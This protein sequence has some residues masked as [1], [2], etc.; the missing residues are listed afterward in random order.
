MWVQRCMMP[1]HWVSIHAVAGVELVDVDVHARAGRPF[2]HELGEH[3][4]EVVY[5]QAH[6]LVLSPLG[7]LVARLRCAAC[8]WDRTWP[9]TR[10]WQAS[11]CSNFQGVAARVMRLPLT[12]STSPPIC[13][14]VGM[15][16]P[17]RIRW[18]TF[19]SGCSTFRIQAGGLGVLIDE[20][21][22]LR[23]AAVRAHGRGERMIDVRSVDAD[24]LGL[25]GH[26]PLGRVLGEPGGFTVVLETVGVLVMPAGDDDDDVALLAPQA[27]GLLQVG[28]G[29][30]LPVLLGNVEHRAVAEVTVGRDGR[31][32]GT[33]LDEMKRRV[34][35]SAGVHGP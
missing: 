5:L 24:H 18:A 26:E 1:S 4:A 22:H 2:G 6:I 8:R 10:T 32:V 17:S 13:S 21:L 29:D 20:A 9:P 33:L 7:R 35:V 25:L 27:C 30:D 16:A 34:H 23:A 15:P 12:T 14:M 11:P 28:G 3:M 31:Q 19:H